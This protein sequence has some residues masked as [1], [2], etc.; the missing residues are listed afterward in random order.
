MH[1]H[2]YNIYYCVCEYWLVHAAVGTYIYYVN[3]TVA[4]YLPIVYI[5]N[6]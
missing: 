1:T 3:H 2:S 6:P 4:V 5:Y